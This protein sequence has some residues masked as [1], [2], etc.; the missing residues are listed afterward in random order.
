MFNRPS[1]PAGTVKVRSKE[2]AAGRGDLTLEGRG[3]NVGG[4][5]QGDGFYYIYNL[6]Y[7]LIYFW[8]C[9][10]FVAARLFSSCGE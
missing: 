10:V 2:R 4:L 7:L 5:T 1:F 6:I 9:R 3:E 8:L